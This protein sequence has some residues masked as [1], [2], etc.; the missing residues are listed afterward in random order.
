MNYIIYTAVE[1]YESDKKL[2]LKWLKDPEDAPNKM[3]KINYQQNDIHLSDQNIWL[4][5]FEKIEGDLLTLYYEKYQKYNDEEFLRFCDNNYDNIN[6]IFKIPILK[7]ECPKDIEIINDII[8]NY[9]YDIVQLLLLF[10]KLLKKKFTKVNI[11]SLD[12]YDLR[13]LNLYNLSY[14]IK[15][16]DISLLSSKD[17]SNLVNILGNTYIYS[18]P[19]KHKNNH[20]LFINRYTKTVCKLSIGNLF[21]YKLA[22]TKTRTPIKSIN[23]MI[24][25]IK[26]DDWVNIL[27]LDVQSK[28]D[29]YDD[30]E[31]TLNGYIFQIFKPATDLENAIIACC[32]KYAQNNRVSRCFYRKIKKLIISKIGHRRPNLSIECL[33]HTKFHYSNHPQRLCCC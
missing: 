22:L 10:R 24:D 14:L 4:F 28:N 18:L 21:A 1:L 27:D 3:L 6:K 23:I 8:K 31:K 26:N 32:N 17:V 33:K 20:Y 7:K 19:W 29:T 2:L 15:Y 16:Y 5:M 13:R 30:F 12:V 25:K 9:T 11:D